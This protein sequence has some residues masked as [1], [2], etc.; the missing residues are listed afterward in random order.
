MLR[1]T[2]STAV[3][4]LASRSIRCLSTTKAA[5]T[6]VSDDLKLTAA[7]MESLDPDVFNMIEA[8]KVRERES[9]LLSPACNYASRSVLDTLQTVLQNKYS[10]G[11][12]RAR[13]YGG[14]ENVDDAEELTQHRALQLF[15]LDPA[16][17]RVNVQPLGGISKSA[18]LWRK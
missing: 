6:A 9:I 5:S 14:N 17:W 18:V 13:Y 10:E 7:S 3:R 11:Y 12:P 15:K 1:C 4:Q 16:E 2:R 8:E